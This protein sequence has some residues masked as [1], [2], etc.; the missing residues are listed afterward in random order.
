LKTQ[1]IDSMTVF[2]F[3]QNLNQHTNTSGNQLIP[4]SPI[5]TPTDPFE[6]I[7]DEATLWGLQTPHSFSNLR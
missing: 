6:K 5:L 2:R 4:Y 7:E 1:T 3:V